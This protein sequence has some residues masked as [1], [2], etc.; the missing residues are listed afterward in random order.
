MPPPPRSR[1]QRAVSVILPTRVSANGGL[2]VEASATIDSHVEAMTEVRDANEAPSGLPL[3]LPNG[4]SLGEIHFQLPAWK[5]VP[6]GIGP[7][8]AV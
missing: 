3:A 2:P 5:K 7:E 8:F 4:G 6:A 1:L